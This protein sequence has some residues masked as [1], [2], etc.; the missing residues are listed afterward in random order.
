MSAPEEAV[1]QAE[2]LEPEF[3]PGEDDQGM[4]GEGAPARKPKNFWP[5]ARRLF[6]LFAPERS[7]FILVVALVSVSVVLTVLAPKVLGQAM[8]VIFDGA[9]GSQLPQTFPGMSLAEIVEAL[10]A[11]GQDDFADVLAGSASIIPG[12]G[13]DF[14]LLGRLILMVLGMYVLASVLMWAQGYILNRIVMKVVYDLRTRIEEKINRLPLKYFDTRQRGDLMSRVT[15]DVDNM[16]QAMQQ[17]FSQLVQSALQVIGI[18]IMMFVVSWQLALIALVALPLSGIIAGVV[19]SKSQKLFTQQWKSTGHLNGHIEES[20]S[21]MELVRVFGRDEQM[22][23]E[24]DERNA[25]LFSSSFGAQFVSGIIMPAMQFVNYLQYVLI[26]VAGALRVASG[27][28][29][30]GDATAFIQYSREFSQP[31]GQIAGMANMLISGVASAERTFELLDAQEQ[32]PDS[33]SAALPKRSDGHVEFRDVAFSYDPQAPLIEGLSFAA[34]PGHTVAIVGPTGAGKTTLVNLVM[35]FYEL[36][37]GQILLDGIDV[38][39]LSRAELRSQVGMV[40]QDTW[41]FDGTIAENIRYGKLDA[42]YDEVVAAAEATMVDRFVR[43]LPDGYDTVVSTDGGSIS[44]GERQLITIARAFLANPSL[45]ILD[46]ATSSVDTRTELLVQQ[47]MNALRT[48]R[49]SFVI[50]HRLSTIRD[51]DTILMMADGRIVER[52]SHDQLF[53]ARGAYYD[54]YMTQFLG[55]HE[56]VEVQVGAPEVSTDGVIEPSSADS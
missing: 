9:I 34:D 53:T 2:D 49:T 4:F 41:L 15:N 10:R 17:A 44:A 28:L 13:I 52:G 39:S 50:A 40:L 31:L 36:D 51:A 7:R 19:G 45:L 54:L 35:R 16:Q 25:K 56:E 3:I 1:D 20:Y 43:Q 47:A 38:R 27:T 23:E 30:I 29:T 24:F 18:A 32:E 42:T 11:A 6:G 21:G 26:A 37:G 33:A 46:E 14:S 8:D 22:L 55:G 48:D 5:S 12:V